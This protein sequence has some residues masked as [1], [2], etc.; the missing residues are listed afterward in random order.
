LRINGVFDPGDPDSLLTYLGLY[1]TV[2]VDRRSDGSQRLSRAP[3]AKHGPSSRT[4]M[5]AH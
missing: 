3:Q 1:E 2:Q 5:V 4:S